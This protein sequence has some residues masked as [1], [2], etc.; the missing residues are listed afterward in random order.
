MGSALGKLDLGLGP[1]LVII[2][3]VVGHWGSGTGLHRRR[4]ASMSAGRYGR[5]I[6]VE[7]FGTVPE[8]MLN[9]G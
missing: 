6:N 2:A 8:E 9:T 7:G 1:A 5:I 4:S 3:F